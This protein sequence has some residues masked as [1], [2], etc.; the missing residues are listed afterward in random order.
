MEKRLPFGGKT[1]KVVGLFAAALISLTVSGCDLDYCADDNKDRKCDEDGTPV[2][3][4]DWIE[5]D[6]KRKYLK[7]YE[8]YDDDEGFGG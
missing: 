5:E 3:P 6:G 2:D 4:N 1:S 8:D 7:L